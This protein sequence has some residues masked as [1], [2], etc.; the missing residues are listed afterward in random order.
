MSQNSSDLSFD[1]IVRT[2]LDINSCSNR[3]PGGGCHAPGSIPWLVV[4]QN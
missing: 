4:A 3:F 2:W 1:Q